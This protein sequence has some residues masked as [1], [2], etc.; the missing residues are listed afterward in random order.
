MS[1][2]EFCGR[3]EGIYENRHT[4][5]W[6][7]YLENDLCGRVMKY[8]LNDAYWRRRMKRRNMQLN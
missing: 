2:V 5:F 3:R 8:F 6:T 7:L 1:L 4:A